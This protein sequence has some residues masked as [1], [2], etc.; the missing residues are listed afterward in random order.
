MKG[1][2]TTA[3]DQTLSGSVSTQ[4]GFLRPEAVVLA[5]GAL[6]P[7]ANLIAPAPNQFTHELARAQPFYYGEAEAGTAPDGELPAA[8]KVALLVYHGG[9]ACRVVDHQGLYIEIEYSSLRKL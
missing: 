1:K 5:K 2:R 6:I 8:T 3:P 9:T 7:N 4:D